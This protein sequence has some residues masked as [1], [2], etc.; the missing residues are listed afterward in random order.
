MSKIPFDVTGVPALPFPMRDP[1]ASGLPSPN[2]K[3]RK[4]ID[5]SPE[6]EPYRLYTVDELGHLP[7]VSWLIDGY[8][9]V[10]ELTV[11]YGKGA[12]FK[13]FLALDWAARIAHAGHSVVYIVAEGASGMRAR[14]PAWQKHHGVIDLPS[15]YL[16]PAHVNLHQQDRVA[17]WLEAMTTQ[18]DSKPSLVVVDT[19]A[20]NFVGGNENNAQEMG[21]FVDGLE[22]VRMELNTAVLVIHHTTKDGDTERGTESLRNASFAMFKVRRVNDTRAVDV[23][24]D[25]MKET[26][27]PPTVKLQP[28]VVPLPELAEGVDSLVAGWPN[29][30][31]DLPPKHME[32]RGKSGGKLLASQRKGLT[33][34]LE[35]SQEASGGASRAVVAK[36]FGVTPKNVVRTIKPLLDAGLLAYEGTTSNR[37][38]VVTAAGREAL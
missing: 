23:E 31:L 35:A 25:R 34:L 24:C 13:S 11:L 4:P 29:S 32:A 22:R 27:P 36:A 2:G 33:R 28:I 38:Y 6:Q 9:A 18:L 20:R 30:P 1:H 3:A 5:L 21:Q 37:R 14:I 26:E 10:G 15:L 12:T 8:L 7:P 17:V 16:M 19:L